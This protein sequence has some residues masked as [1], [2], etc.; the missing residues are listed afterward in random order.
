MNTTQTSASQEADRGLM[1]GWGTALFL[2][3]YMAACAPYRLGHLQWELPAFPNSLASPICYKVKM[4]FAPC[5]SQLFLPCSKQLIQVRSQ[6]K[7]E[8]PEKNHLPMLSH[9]SGRAFPCAPRWVLNVVPRWALPTS[10]C[11]LT[12][13]LRWQLMTLLLKLPCTGDG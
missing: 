2:P 3:A 5:L 13:T 7:P 1:L 11:S 6:Q 4:D 8:E 12:S 10:R 9:L